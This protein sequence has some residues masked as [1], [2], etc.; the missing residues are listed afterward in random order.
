MEAWV[1]CHLEQGFY[2]LNYLGLKVQNIA[3]YIVVL[4]LCVDFI[5][6]VFSDIA[7]SVGERRH[8]L[9]T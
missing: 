5:I 4:L 1:K 2:R 9:I 3:E 7:F 6:L 8:I